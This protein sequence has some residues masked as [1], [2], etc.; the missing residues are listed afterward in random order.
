MVLFC[1]I[2]QWS[3]RR[4]SLEM[5]QI[6]VSASFISPCPYICLPVNWQ[7]FSICILQITLPVLIE[8]TVNCLEFLCVSWPECLIAVTGQ[9][10]WGVK[11][12]WKWW[13]A[14]PA[15]TLG[16]SVGW[17][18]ESNLGSLILG[19]HCLCKKEGT[20]CF[21]AALCWLNIGGYQHIPN[22]LFFSIINYKV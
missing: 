15:Q 14:K 1:I 9:I 16:D 5:P 11:C 22:F 6:Q 21:H 19:L 20:G 13:D 18:Q 4:N 7:F 10:C 3:W 8:M 2:T 12:S 17:N